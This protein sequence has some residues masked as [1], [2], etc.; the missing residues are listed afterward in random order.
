MTG[1][2][3]VVGLWCA[4]VLAVGGAAPIAGADSGGAAGP[5][6][7]GVAMLHSGVVGVRLTASNPGP[8]AV[9]DA[10]VRMRWSRPLADRQALPAACTRS[11]AD[12]VLCGVGAL[13]AGGDGAGIGLVARLA[14][15]SSEVWLE[16]DTVWRGGAA[17]GD[18]ASEPQRVLVL[19][20]G[21]PYYF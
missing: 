15:V 20:T 19:D 10:T 9:P 5:E 3:R 11:G 4:A 14:G 7:H 13:P 2:S 21:D 1:R 8:S 17:D 18:R 12:T 16:V 6:Y